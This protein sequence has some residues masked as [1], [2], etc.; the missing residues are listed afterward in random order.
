MIYSITTR[1]QPISGGKKRPKHKKN[2]RKN[3]KLAKL[4]AAMIGREKWPRKQL[5]A[6]TSAA[7][8]CTQTD[9]IP[10]N[11]RRPRQSLFSATPATLQV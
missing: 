8:S 3:E 7:N 1:K 11:Y 4:P 10:N 2:G 6:A 9:T 5:P